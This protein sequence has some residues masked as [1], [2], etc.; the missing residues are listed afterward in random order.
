M[1]SFLKEIHNSKKAWNIKLFLRNLLL[2]RFFK[3]PHLQERKI[4]KGKKIPKNN[5]IKNVLI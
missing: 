4:L 3:R 1:K 2:N 5:I